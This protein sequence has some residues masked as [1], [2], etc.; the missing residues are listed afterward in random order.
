MK[1]QSVRVT[2]TVLVGMAGLFAAVSGGVSAGER[3][4][5]RAFYTAPPVVPHE[6]DNLGNEDCQICH[7]EVLDLG[8]RV[9][10]PTPHPQFSNCLQ[11][12]VGTEPPAFLDKVEIESD[13]IGLEEPGRIERENEVAPP[14]LPHRLFLRDRCLSCHNP[15]HPR[16]NMR[17]SHPERSNCLQCHVAVEERQF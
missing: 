9:S 10:V 12:H 17:T 4:A 8:D 11:C 3:S 14:V 5:N 1:L 13:W 7:E 6:L 15:E 2:L 16:V